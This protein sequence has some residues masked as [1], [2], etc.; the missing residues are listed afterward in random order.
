MKF[1]IELEES[2]IKLAIVEYIAKRRPEANAN[3]SD[4]TLYVDGDDDEPLE[5]DGDPID[6]HQFYFR[7]KAKTPAESAVPLFDTRT[8]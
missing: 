7:A 8:A 4:V 3:A 1:V 6:S 5:H 2:E